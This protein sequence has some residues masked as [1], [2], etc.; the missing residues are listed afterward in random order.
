MKNGPGAGG[1]LKGRL[2]QARA[3]PAAPMSLRSGNGGSS[4]PAK[5][6]R[7]RAGHLEAGGSPRSRGIHER[8][9]LL[10]KICS[11]LFEP[12][13][14]IASA[15][16]LSMS[17]ATRTTRSAQP[18]CARVVLFPS[19]GRSTTSTA[20]RRMKSTR[21]TSAPPVVPCRPDRSNNR[22]PSCPGG[23]GARE[24]PVDSCAKDH[25]GFEATAN[26]WP[27]HSPPIPRCRDV[28]HRGNSG[29][30]VPWAA[31]ALAAW[32]GP[33]KPSERRRYG[34]G[35]VETCA[36]PFGSGTGRPGSAVRSLPQGIGCWR[37]G[38]KIQQG[39]HAGVLW[40][41]KRWKG[42]TTRRT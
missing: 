10:P 36:A 18:S 26:F 37:Y 17:S 34:E 9:A 3:R 29:W 25:P 1:S 40:R 35:D 4:L 38:R 23:T 21:T 28:G 16:P 7:L 32:R 19:I 15:P 13:G 27:R 8:S 30:R 14:S 24:L 20:I 41:E 31:L 22:H 39:F 11:G 33:G 5:M 42:T 6:P 2:L 12:R